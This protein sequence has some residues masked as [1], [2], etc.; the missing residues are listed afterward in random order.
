MELQIQLGRDVRIMFLF[1]GEGDAEADGTSSGFVRAAVGGF[2]DARSAPGADKEALPLGKRERPLGHLE[3]EFAA[4]FVISGTAQV[5]FGDAHAM[6]A[7][8]VGARAGGGEGL[9]LFEA[10][11]GD[12]LG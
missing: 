12:F 8:G 7:F 11:A 6:R 4:G 3:G 10:L 2:H 1:E 5:D 9:G